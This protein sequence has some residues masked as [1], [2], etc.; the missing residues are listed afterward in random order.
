M[1]SVE[2]FT[3]IS[4][5][6]QLYM[7]D[8]ETVEVTRRARFDDAMCRALHMLGVNHENTSSSSSSS[9]NE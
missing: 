4:G 7:L 2:P 6:W 5:P 1:P 8:M 9:K 3:A